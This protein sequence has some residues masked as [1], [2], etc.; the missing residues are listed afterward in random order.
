MVLAVAL[1]LKAPYPL[2]QL[3]TTSSLKPSQIPL[4]GWG[5]SHFLTPLNNIYWAFPVC[6]A[7]A[8]VSPQ[9]HST[10]PRAWEGGT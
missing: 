6:P 9:L 3:T 5:Y 7:W 1:T 2:I 10:F 4:T 8:R